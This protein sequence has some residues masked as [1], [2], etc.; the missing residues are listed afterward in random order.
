MLILLFVAPLAALPQQST[1]PTQKWRKSEKTD[2]NRGMSYNQFTLA[3]K[4]QKWPE[5]DASTRPGLEVDC[6]TQGRSSGSK[7]DF[8]HAYFFVGVPLTIEYVEPDAI[9]TGIG[10]F[11]KIDVR[12]RL[13][14]DKEKKEQWSPGPDKSSVTIPKDV[15]KKMIVAHNVV[16]TVNEVNAAEVSAQFE[17]PDSSE[18]GQACDLGHPKK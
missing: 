17:M 3:G 5:K 8:W 1:A 12:Y 7:G 14:N 6:M 2:S 15:L 4:F 11:Q 13:D 18:V 10:Y 16:I 9:T